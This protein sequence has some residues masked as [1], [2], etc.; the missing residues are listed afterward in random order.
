MDDGQF[1]QL[2]A[3][4]MTQNALLA[5]LVLKAETNQSASDAVA[6]EVSHALYKQIAESFDI[7]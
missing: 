6:R 3:A 4:V 7:R 5:K 1:F 2:L